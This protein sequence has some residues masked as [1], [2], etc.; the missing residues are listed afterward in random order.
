MRYVTATEFQ[1]S[2]KKVIAEVRRKNKPVTVV[3]RGQ[4]VAVICPFEWMNKREGSTDGK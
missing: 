3:R 1:K 2:V 4:P